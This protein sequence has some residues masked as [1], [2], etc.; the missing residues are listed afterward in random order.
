MA[1]LK[2]KSGFRIS[3][4]SSDYKNDVVEVEV[5]AELRQAGALELLEQTGSLVTKHE[6]V[7]GHVSEAAIEA[8][9]TIVNDFESVSF[10]KTRERRGREVMKVRRR[11]NHAPPWATQT[12]VQAGY[13][14]GRYGQK[15]PG[16]RKLGNFFDVEM[17]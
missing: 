13:I 12:R 14:A 9:I 10:Q 5:E 6:N 3:A 11:M 8:T 4:T 16:V 1:S 7:I 2:D 15:R 17:G